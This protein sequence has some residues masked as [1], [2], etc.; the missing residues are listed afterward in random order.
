MFSTQGK[1]YTSV[2]KAC[3]L[4]PL[5]FAPLL[6]P[7]LCN[8]FSPPEKH[9]LQG[10]NVT[11]GRTT[12]AGTDPAGCWA[13]AALAEATQG[14]E[15]HQRSLQLHA[16]SGRAVGEVECSPSTAPDPGSLKIELDTLLGYSRHHEKQVVSI[17]LLYI[18]INCCVWGFFL[19]VLQMLNG[20]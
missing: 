6:S 17:I 5:L 9:V 18:W 1:L 8:P 3:K 7:F 16:A 10:V 2:H 13:A 20:V 12:L 14:R 15:T 19:A 11:L 4:S